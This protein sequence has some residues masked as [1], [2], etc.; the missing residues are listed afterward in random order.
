MKNKINNNFF[1][2]MVF[3][4][5]NAKKITAYFK[6]GQSANYTMDIYDLLITDA[7]IDCI[8][9]GETGEIIFSK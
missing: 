2:E 3:S 1:L 6:N 5:T 9:D 4:P 8:T 7:D